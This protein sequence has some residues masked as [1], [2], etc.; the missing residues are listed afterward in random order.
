M[1]G[2][3]YDK[4]EGY[5]VERHSALAEG[6]IEMCAGRRRVGGDIYAAICASYHLVVVRAAVQYI[7]LSGRSLHCA[8]GKPI[9]SVQ[10]T[11]S[12]S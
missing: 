10:A 12:L 7:R 4:E 1:E 3:G 5:A 9:V 8:G 2:A 6:K 11:S